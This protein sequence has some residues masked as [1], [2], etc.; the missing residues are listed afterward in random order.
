MNKLDIL[1]KI[2]EAGVVGA[3]GAGFPTHIKYRSKARKLLINAAECE[4]L[5]HTDQYEMETYPDEIVKG[6]LL[7]KE[8]IEAEEA[9]IGIKTK[10]EK[11]VEA[12]EKS[13]E[14]LQAPIRIHKMESFYP[15]GDEQ[16]LIY[17][18][19]DV[20][21]E[22]GSIPISKGIVVSNVTTIKNV[23][24]AS[25]DKS[26]T[27]KTVTVNGEVKT[28]CVINVPIGTSIEECIKAAGGSKLDQY[29]LILGG[30]MMGKM[31]MGSD[32]QSS[33]VT[34]TLGGI[35]ILPID[36]PLISRR[37]QS[38]QKIKNQ[39]AS[40]CIQ[41][42]FCTELCP[43]YLIGHPLHP[44]EVMKAFGNDGDLQT[45]KLLQATLCCEC[46]ICELYS[47]P[48]GLS[49]RIVNAEVKK[50]LREAG[51]P[52]KEYESMGIHPMEE[53]RRLSTDVL[54]KKISIDKYY[55]VH[56]FKYL[57]LDVEEVSIPLSQ[58][59][60]KPSKP[61]V[62]KGDK[63]ILGQTIGQVNKEDMGACVHSSLDGVVQEVS[64]KEIRIKASGEN[65]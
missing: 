32:I 16:G 2:Y 3:G 31:I 41:C 30:P 26:V 9:V 62:K 13:I 23:Y 33:F 29:A 65:D 59:I 34:K 57:D 27:H 5:L 25:V 10:H 15:A 4:P 63:V 42:D 19:F 38:L 7:A 20:A 47:C 18:V 60:G 46:G 6:I 8:T 11:S 40:A 52:K 48:M 17:E 43:R 51:V 35:I 44:H 36:H 1:E 49:P 55:K 61:I 14:K 28:P 22:P 45:E 56:N 12:L 54:V 53:Y 50:A 39:T 58:H 37:L 21:L 24:K 64:D